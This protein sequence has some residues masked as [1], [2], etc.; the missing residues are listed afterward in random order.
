MASRVGNWNTVADLAAR[1][2]VV[3]YVVRACA[4]DGL[5]LPDEIGQQFLAEH[6]ATQA[7]SMLLEHEL[8]QI[9]TAFGAA[10]VPVLVLKGPALVRTIY[11]DPG[12]RPYSDLDLTIHKQHEALAASLLEG[13]GYSEFFYDGDLARRAPSEHFCEAS[14]FHRSFAGVY[15]RSLVEL[16]LD[17][18]Q[19]AV[20]PACERDRWER[21]QV[22]P[23]LPDGRMLAPVDQLVQLCVHAH[24]HGFNRLIW[25]KDLDLLLRTHADALDWRLIADVAHKEGV[26]A[27][28]WYALQLTHTLLG[29]PLPRGTAAVQPSF[30]TRALYRAIWPPARVARLEGFVRRR[31][32]Q[33][34]MDES[35]RGMLPS[36]LL[37]G[38]RRTRVHLMLSALLWRQRTVG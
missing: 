26:A 16:H 12:L 37:M 9:L 34:F 15:N 5:A 20:A 8:Q 10:Q 30:V 36:V 29:T 19:L 1:H 28:A 14:A 11:S 2:R 31:A 24:K 22:V 33:M 35:W 4:R 25:L 32:V 13:C 27:S 17:P 21:S 3:G 23:G 38:R 6:L 18:F 7:V